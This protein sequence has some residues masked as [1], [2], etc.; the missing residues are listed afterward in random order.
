V[1]RRAVVVSLVSLVDHFLDIDLAHLLW[2]ITKISR[3]GR[4]YCSLR[5]SNVYR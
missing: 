2:R 5:M 4:V 1:L 3:V